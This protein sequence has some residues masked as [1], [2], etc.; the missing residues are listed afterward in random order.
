MTGS[1]IDCDRKLY[2]L[3]INPMRWVKDQVFVLHPIKV[4]KPTIVFTDSKIKLPTVS[5][6]TILITILT[7]RDSMHQM[8][9]VDADV[10]VGCA[11]ML[12]TLLRNLEGIEGITLVLPTKAMCTEMS[13]KF[14]LVR[15]EGEL[16]GGHYDI[17]WA[18]YYSA[19]GDRL[20]GE[21]DEANSQFFR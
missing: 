1:C 11:S 2:R 21:V 5:E 12:N 4:A 18:V 10:G 8:Y 15:A 17:E 6:S 20:Y 13:A 7:G 9:R 3:N 16:E 19:E 14:E